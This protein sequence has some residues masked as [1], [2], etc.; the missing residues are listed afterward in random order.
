MTIL[1]FI[2]CS[3]IHN[4]TQPMPMY[5]NIHTH[6]PAEHND[7]T[8]SI[9]SLYEDFGSMRPGL[10]YSIGLHPAYLDD[11]VNKFGQIE[12]LAEQPG[13]LAIGEC[14]LDK[15]VTAPMELQQEIFIKHIALANRVGKP[16]II[17]CVQAHQL[18]AEIFAKH[19]PIV[20][21]VFHGYNNR[22]A[23]AAMFAGYHFSFGAAILNDKLPAA[24]ILRTTHSDQFFLETDESDVSIQ[25]IY[26]KAAAI[27]NILVEDLIRSQQYHFNS[28]FNLNNND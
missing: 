20:P 27:R 15:L 22:P 24:D 4:F 2:S 3:D 14:G 5:Y 21:V 9:Q 8:L 28:L 17:H 11:H 7:H 16:L 19:K 6:Q 1:T 12:K 26:M 10:F 25:E 13:V 23:I 18:I